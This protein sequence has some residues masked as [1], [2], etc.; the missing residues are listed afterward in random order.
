MLSKES[1]EKFKKIFKEDYGV[2]YSDE[3]A[4]EA[5]AKKA[6]LWAIF[7]LNQLVSKIELC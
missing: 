2:E 5:V 1:I 3:E 4:R 6:H 7:I